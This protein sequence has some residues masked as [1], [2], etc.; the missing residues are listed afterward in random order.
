VDSHVHVFPPDIA[1][2]R[3]AYLGRDARFDALYRS[4]Q[5]RMATAEEV[6]RAMDENGVALSVVL[7]F[8]FKDR[9]LCREVNDYVLEAVASAPARLAGMAAVSPGAP[10]ALAE[11][12]RCLDAGLRGCGELT[13]DPAES[14]AYADLAPLAECLRERGLPLMV[15]ASEPLGHDYPGKGRFTPRACLDLAQAHPGLSIV[16]SHLGGGLFVY[17]LMPE[18]RRALADVYYDTAAVAYLYDPAVYEVVAAAAGAGKL[19]F[20]SDYPLLPP[21]RCLVGIERLTAGDRE[22]VQSGNARKVFK[23]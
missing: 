7:G 4:P 5:A 12:E 8:A 19:I 3:D 10:G 17:E 13:F 9:G 15:H 20:G 22:A 23:L 11:L 18:V 14:G 2:D 21:D 16:F 6:V 1:G